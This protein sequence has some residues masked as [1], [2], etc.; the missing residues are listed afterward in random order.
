MFLTIST[1]CPGSAVLMV[2]ET[3]FIIFRKHIN[4]ITEKNDPGVATNEVLEVGEVIL[5]HKDLF[6][7][8]GSVCM[9]MYGTMEQI[10]PLC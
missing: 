6:L 4:I 2:W 8:P 1:V 10:I 3:Q 5:D 7:C 9:V